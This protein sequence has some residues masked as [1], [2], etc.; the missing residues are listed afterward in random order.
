MLSWIPFGPAW[1]ASTSMNPSQTH[2]ARQLRGGG[3]GWPSIA[4]PSVHREVNC[5]SID[6]DVM[7]ETSF[8]LEYHESR[9]TWSVILSSHAANLNNFLITVRQ[10]PRSPRRRDHAHNA[11]AEILAF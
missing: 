9:N 2:D 7:Q 8:A 1:L 11:C 4:S 6:S 5:S 3:S 10:L